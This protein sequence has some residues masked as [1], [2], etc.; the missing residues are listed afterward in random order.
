MKDIL[1][2]NIL[3]NNIYILNR[4]FFIYYKSS[5]TRSIFGLNSISFKSYTRPLDQKSYIH[6]NNILAKKTRGPHPILLLNIIDINGE[7]HYLLYIGSHSDAHM[8]RKND[9]AE[10]L[11]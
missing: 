5:I 4:E 3:I 7:P 10:L 9:I 1:I 8:Y 6:T 2:N 11:Y